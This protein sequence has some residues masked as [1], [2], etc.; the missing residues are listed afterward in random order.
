[1]FANIGTTFGTGNGST[2]FN[3]P[4]LRGEFI[5]GWANARSVDTGRAFGSFQADE[6]KAHT[7]SH[8]TSNKT[9]ISSS[10]YGTNVTVAANLVAGTPS[11]GPVSDSTGGAETRP[12]NV[13]LMYIIKFSHGATVRGLP[14]LRPSDG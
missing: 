10:A 5:R 13:A 1:L 9:G 4:D 2:T 11:T 8:N 7:H 14:Q 3:I 12:R 6:L